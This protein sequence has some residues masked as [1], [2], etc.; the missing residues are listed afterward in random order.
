MKMG[1]EVYMGIIGLLILIIHRAALLITFPNRFKLRYSIGILLLA[2]ALTNQFRNMTG[3]IIQWNALTTF[4]NCILMCW[5][6]KGSVS[7]IFFAFYFQYILTISLLYLSEAVIGIFINPNSERFTYVLFVTMLV[8]YAAFVTLSV[9]YGRKLFLKLLEHGRTSEW[10]LYASGAV[11]SFIFLTVSRDFPGSTMQY[12][13]STLFVI[14]SFAVFCFAI[15]NAHERT[16]QRTDAEFAQSIISTGREHYQKM[17]EMYDTLAILRHDYKYHLNTIGELVMNEDMEG[18]KKYLESVKAQAPENELQYYCSNSVINALLGSY[19]ERCAKY[20]FEFTIRL[21]MPEALSVPN[22][23]MCIVLGNLLENAF[24]ACQKLKELKRE[25][26]PCI[27]LVVKKNETQLLIMVK[28]SFNGLITQSGDGPA[29]TKKD[30]GFGLKSVRAV[31]A[32]YDGYLLTEWDS[33][34]FTAYVAVQL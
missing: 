25:R 1:T 29:S 27:E 31:A 15:I 11:Y 2:L 6:L 13:M 4:F 20:N 19:A 33:E 10:T 30:G 26:L 32:R 17:N 14:W 21:D 16:K 7:Q 8:L 18:I 34:A 23:E 3:D 28:N 12:I 5:L 9:K 22:Y 24:E